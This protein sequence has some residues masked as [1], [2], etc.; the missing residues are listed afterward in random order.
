[1]VPLEYLST[2]WWTLEMLLINC[3]INLNLTWS[4]NCVIVATAV[5]NQGATFSITDTKL[6]IPVVNLSTQDNGKMLEQLK[7]GFKSTIDWNKY[8]WKKSTERP[9]SY[10]DY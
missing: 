2:F 4:A 1:M 7:S 9:E 8:Q 6:Y 5:A 10:F 3:E